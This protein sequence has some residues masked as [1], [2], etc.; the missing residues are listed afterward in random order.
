MYNSK[1]WISCKHWGGKLRVGNLDKI[2]VFNRFPV[3]K[4]LFCELLDMAI[5][6]DNYI[7]TIFNLEP[8]TYKR[9]YFTMTERELKFVAKRCG[10]PKLANCFPECD[11]I[12]S[13]RGHCI[14]LHIPAMALKLSEI[15]LLPDDPEGKKLF[16]IH[17][18][19]CLFHEL[20]HA[21]HVSRIS[22]NY[23]DTKFFGGKSPEF[24]REESEKNA[25]NC[26]DRLGK[27][28]LE[29]LSRN[30]LNLGSLADQLFEWQ[31]LRPILM[32]P[33]S[34]KKTT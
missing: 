26:E 27:R 8:R 31:K 9:I 20:G 19:G 30:G 15:R 33:R 2:I 21:C 28:L 6:A 13:S 22:V 24:D 1:D 3:N 12:F 10:D 34:Q 7:S 23:V 17:L 14:V 4:K 25:D 18:F 29:I 5:K 16:A 11:A 32:P